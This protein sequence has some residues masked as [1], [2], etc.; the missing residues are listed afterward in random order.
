MFC[1]EKMS[2]V[3]MVNYKLTGV[4]SWVKNVPKSVQMK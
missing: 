3:F 4:V 2:L 1:D